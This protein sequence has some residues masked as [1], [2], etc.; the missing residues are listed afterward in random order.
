MPPWQLGFHVNHEAVLEDLVT[1]AFSYKILS[2]Q[3]FSDLVLFDSFHAFCVQWLVLNYLFLILCILNCKLPQAGLWKSAEISYINIVLNAKLNS[4]QKNV[5]PF[6]ITNWKLKQVAM[7]IQNKN[8]FILQNFYPT[9]LPSKSF[10]QWK[11]YQ[12]AR[13]VIGFSEEGFC[14]LSNHQLYKVYTH[15]SRERSREIP[16]LYTEAAKP[17]IF[18]I[19]LK[20]W[21]L[22]KLY[23]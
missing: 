5:Q 19:W 1:Q 11:K 8:I 10:S 20:I 2:Y 6:K 22:T 16:V 15:F 7:Y 9:F 21:T 12:S 23:I 14:M 17:Q 18:H 3:V 4:Q 13:H